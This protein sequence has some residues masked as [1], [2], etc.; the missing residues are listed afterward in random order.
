MSDEKILLVFSD[1]VTAQQLEHAIL[2][3]QGYDVVA[4]GSLK[5]AVSQIE[6]QP[7][8]LVIIE[9]NNFE[10]DVKNSII[11]LIHDHPTLPVLLFF[12]SNPE[13]LTTNALRAGV[14]DILTPPLASP[15]TLST[16]Q[17]AL[18]RKRD[19]EA[20]VRSRTKRDTRSLQKR[21]NDLETLQRVGR[22]ITASLNLD[23]VLAAVV[24]AA[25]ELT[26]AEEGSLM[27]L[28]EA[29]GELSIRA[30][31]NFR[32]EF[33]RT[34]RMPVKDSLLG[35]VLHDG[36]PMIINEQTP[37]KIK[38]SFLVRSLVY[39]PLVTDGKALGVLGV[40]N[41]E[42][43]HTFTDYELTL[44]TSLADYAVIAIKNAH[45]FTASESE[46]RQ[47]EQILTNVKDGVIVLDKNKCLMLINQTARHMFDL[48]SL[49]LSGLPVKSVVKNP[50]F[51]EI[52]EASISPN[53]TGYEINLEDGT[54]FNT[55]ITSIPEIGFA[56]TMQDITHLKELDRVKSEFVTT[57]SHDL[58]SP[59]TAIMGYTELVSRSGELNSKQKVFIQRVQNNVQNITA[60]IND[61]L[62]L[63][64]I[65]AGIDAHKESV[66][67]P[68]L[69][70]H[71]LEGFE[72]ALA[73][74]ALTLKEEIQDDIPPLQ[75][76]PIRLRQMLSNLV[77]N[78]INYT[79]RGGKI[80]IR[81]EVEG[82][83]IILQV[84][85]TGPGIL[86]AEQ[87]FIFDKFFRVS[88][89]PTDVA[90]TGLGLAIVKSIV[91]NH[92]GRIWVNSTPGKGSVFVIVL[93]V[94]HPLQ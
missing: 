6:S 77:C 57:V 31:R 45:H 11:Q 66:H 87:P 16:I 37:Q 79:P 33:V 46:R 41:R 27:L 32:E 80:G 25:V 20:W 59:L 68:P 75:G 15:E 30:A 53:K 43:S 4:K 83:Q 89:L 90:G 76:N 47:W 81:I 70:R 93:P 36:R 74:K 72:S 18:Q 48:A 5:E 19:L 38:T 35:Q 42:S 21:V 13:K 78:A 10:G 71:T 1:Q 40:D 69:L 34:F 88:N 29:S 60:L 54:V 14:V 24:D 7:P 39:L 8:E 17:S 23:S 92:Q 63:G 3:P 44:L 73:E 84:S 85:D 12:P 22:T 94:T 56:I 2:K 62:D 55:Q 61:L 50:D 52:I 28:D 58:R 51:L 82:A 91:E 26:G 9:S 86:P 67:I 65:E 49:E 64:R